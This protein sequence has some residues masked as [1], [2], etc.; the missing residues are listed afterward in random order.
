MHR[1]PIL[2][3]APRHLR[4]EEGHHALPPSGEPDVEERRDPAAIAHPEGYRLRV[5]PRRVLVVCREAAG[6]FYARQTLRQ[7]VRQAGDDDAIPCLEIVDAPD[8]AHRGVMLDISRDRVPT[9]E[10]LR[11]WVDL[12][13]EWKINQLQL[14]VEHTFAYDGHQEVWEHASPMTGEQFESLDGWCRERHIELV[15]NQNSFGHMERW[16]VHTRYAPLAEVPF[17]EERLR[18]GE[19]PGTMSLCPTDPASLDLLRDLYGQLL[20]HFTGGMFNVGCDET[21]DLGQGRSKTE[22]GRRGVARVYLDFLESIHREVWRRG[23]R[24]Q[25]WGDIVLQHPE[26]I[27]ELPQEVVALDWGYEAD[28]PFPDECR[29]FAEAGLEFYVCPGTSSWLSIGG[30][31]ENMLANVRSAAEAGLAHGASGLLVTDWGDHGHWQ[32][33]PVSYPGVAYGA[34]MAWCAARNADLALSEVLDRQV[35]RDVHGVVGRAALALGNV[36]RDTGVQ[37]K[38][39]SALALLLLFPDRPLDEGRFAGITREAL[40]GADSLIGRAASALDREGMERDDA[41]V[42]SDELRSAA[43]LLGH[44]CR[45]GIARLDAGGVS[46]SSLPDPVRGALGDELAGIL[47]NYRRLWLERSR[48]GGLGDS[49]GR[50]ESLLAR[51]RSA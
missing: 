49:A 47:T 13:A 40:E 39:A 12:L 50:L 5:E 19:R 9:M 34:A 44:A 27:P 11:H 24:M 23:R 21:V 20:P 33:L 46:P 29:R 43:A 36:Y 18:A 15:P 45:L 51:Y 10:T 16:L 25:F 8:Y 37:P 26:V 30:R 17:P 4:L 32:P 3:P 28:H 22:V 38:N 14:Y 1:S 48:P 2:L 31:V 41:G 6:A 35:F 7:L 42:V